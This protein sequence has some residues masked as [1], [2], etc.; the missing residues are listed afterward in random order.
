L[1]PSG[2]T[3]ELLFEVFDSIPPFANIFA[4]F[5]IYHSHMSIKYLNTEQ[6][7]KR[8]HSLLGPYASIILLI[9]TV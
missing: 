5:R 6:P 2:S 4:E 9:F 3:L 8:R 1:E 7:R